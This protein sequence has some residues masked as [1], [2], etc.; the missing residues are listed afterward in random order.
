MRERERERVRERE[1]EMKGF[2]ALES[3]SDYQIER[4][5]VCVCVCMTCRRECVFRG[6]RTVRRTVNCPNPFAP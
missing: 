2:E 6:V 3:F 1:R 5:R 4:E